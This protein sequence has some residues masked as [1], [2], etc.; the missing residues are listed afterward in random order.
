MRMN[1]KDF[2][3]KSIAL[4]VTIS[5]SGYLFENKLMAE[6][7]TKHVLP[8][9]GIMA[10]DAH[11]HPYHLHHPP[12]SP[13]G[14]IKHLR[15]TA[16]VSRMKEAGL[17]G[18]VFAAL[19]DSV[20][21][22]GSNVSAYTDTIEQI[23]RI[24]NFER[25]KK[26]RLVSN[27]SDLKFTGNND[28]FAAIMAIEGGDALEGDITNIDRFHEKGVRLITILHKID[29]EIGFNQESKFDGQLTPFGKKVVEKMNEKGMI[30]DVAHSNTLTL[31]SVSEV[32][33]L[34][35]LDS[36]TAPFPESEENNFPNRAR[37]WNEMELIAKSGGVICTMPIAYKLGSYER[38]TLA[39]WASEILLMK[40]RLGI[41]HVGLG[42]DNAG[43]PS[44]V[45]GWESIASLPDLIE[46]LLKIG[47]SEK[48]I[49]AFTGGNFLRIASK[50]LH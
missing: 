34:P 11:S 22:K 39:H 15:T 42:S 18:S 2:F 40:N 48:D 21:I 7:A 43:L 28:L 30:V 14:R 8:F 36:H 24:E 12:L 4:G 27:V 38:T 16:T 1:R 47:L 17:V 46:E 25:K 33:Q 29:N 10:F 35:L 49:L 23:E 50:C 3:K 44:L 41:E 31:K 19:G 26:I 6:S 32:S 37:S 45:E 13:Y 5:F 20:K 9:E